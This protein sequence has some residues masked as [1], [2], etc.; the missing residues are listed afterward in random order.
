MKTSLAFLL[1]PM[2]ASAWSTVLS[3]ST[4]RYVIPDEHEEDFS[5]ITMPRSST[6]APAESLQQHHA[7]SQST[8]AWLQ[9]MAQSYQLE[10]GEKL[11]DVLLRESSISL[12]GSSMDDIAT[13]CAKTNLAIASHDFVRDPTGE[14]IYC[15]GNDAFISNFEYTW[16]EFVQLPSRYC[17]ETDDEVKERNKL[18]NESRQRLERT[19]D[20]IPE[21]IRITKNK[22]RILLQGV[23]LWNVYDFQNDVRL[24]GY[25]GSTVS[26]KLI[27]D[28]IDRGDIKAIGQAVWIR[29][30]VESI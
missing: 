23:N 15:Y 7:T 21:L 17:V 14:P 20:E 4:Q 24:I 30:V 27:R 6:N 3:R 5:S 22:R 13:V 16:E 28:Q 10:R 26:A 12:T 2:T 25:D 8:I 9:Q 1:A 18:L 29:K 19:S 11:L